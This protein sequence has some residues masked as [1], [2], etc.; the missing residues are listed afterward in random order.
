MDSSSPFAYLLLGQPTL[1][2]QLRMGIFAA[3]DQR[4]A[5]RYVLGP[6]DLA[7]SANYL[8][9]HL[10]VAGR[11]DPLRRRH[12]R[13]SPSSIQRPAPGAQQRSHR[14]PDRCRL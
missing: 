10:A 12:S 14:R 11:A 7:E 13:P 2:R 5:T 4:I 9:H 8:R 6:M 3:L 1:A